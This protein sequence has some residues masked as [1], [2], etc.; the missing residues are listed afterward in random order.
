MEFRVWFF[1]R[2]FPHVRHSVQTI[3]TGMLHDR[4]SDAGDHACLT[5][6]AWNGRIFLAYLDHCLN[7]QL[8][9][10]QASGR[11]DPELVLATVATRSLLLWFCEQEGAHKRYLTEE[12]ARTIHRH[13]IQY[14]QYAEA[15]SQHA[16]GNNLLRW[17]VLPKHHDSRLIL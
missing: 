8:E 9:S 7:H 13:G 17:K 1:C 5:L 4:S 12:Q 14:L 10:N 6:K 11:H 15:L 3:T 16:S 2:I